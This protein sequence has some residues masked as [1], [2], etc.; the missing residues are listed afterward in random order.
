MLITLLILDLLI[1]AGVSVITY[2]LFR[3]P[4]AASTIDLNKPQVV[5]NE[6]AGITPKKGSVTVLDWYHD[7]KIKKKRLKQLQGEEI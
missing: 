5:V 2:K 7:D 6:N 1:L 3:R 4:L